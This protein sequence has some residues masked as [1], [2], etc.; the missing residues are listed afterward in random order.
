MT[1]KNPPATPLDILLVIMG[2]SPYNRSIWTGFLDGFQL[3]GHSVT[4]VDA[5]EIPEPENLPQLPDL[6]FAVHGSNVPLEKIRAYR[7]REV[8]TAVYLLDEPYEVDRSSEWARDYDQVFSVDRAT[9]PV[10]GRFTRAAHLPLAYNHLVFNPQGPAVQ[11]RILV[12]GT[13]FDTREPCLAAIRDRWGPQITWVGPGWKN[14]SA[15]GQHYEHFVTPPDC[16]KFYR[17]ADVVINIHRD[18][19]W[20]H[21]GDL[22]RE[23]IEATHLNPRFWETAGCNSFQL[24]SYRADIDAYAPGS[25]TFNSVDQL[26][27]K[28]GYFL[29]N[30]KARQTQLQRLY[31]KVRNHTYENRCRSVLDTLQL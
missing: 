10:H 31:K 1:R 27:Q 20:S 8:P 19:L 9:V 26:V 18:S 28:L 22:N 5:T 3:L 21:F 16:A 7:S 6:L 25:A 24:C 17:G 23:R 14:F 29:D 11:S 15:A 12:L 2:Q 13:P 30:E 4:V